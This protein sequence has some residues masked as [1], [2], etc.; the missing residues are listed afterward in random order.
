VPVDL[1]LLQVGLVNVEPLAQA[2]L[3]Q[4]LGCNPTSGNLA[5]IMNLNQEDSHIVHLQPFPRTAVDGCFYV[6]SYVALIPMQDCPV[7]H[8]KLNQQLSQRLIC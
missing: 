2:I 3:P 7:C 4:R 6:H 1:E 5:A 8:L